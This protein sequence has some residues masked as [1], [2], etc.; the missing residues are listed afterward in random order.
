[1]IVRPH[2][3]IVWFRR[4]LRLADNPA[5]TAALER[6]ET[7][8][9]LYIHSP[10]EDEAGA[11]GAA[12]RFW[13][14]ESL[15]ALD[16]DLRRRGSELVLA[17]GPVRAALTDL[18]RTT[19]A[20]AVYWNRAYEP[21]LTARDTDLKRE[22]RAAGT[23]VHSSNASL[24]FEP[25]DI[26]TGAGSA[27]RVY[28]PYARQ[29]RAR[30]GEITPPLPAP[31]RI[32]GPQ[33]APA[34]LP[35]EA[36]G[37]R[38]AH[39]W[40]EGLARAWAPGESGAQQ[41]LARFM[42]GP[43]AGY[44]EAR[45]RPAVPGTSRL[46][47]HLHFGELSPRQALAALGGGPH[48]DGAGGEAFVRELLWREFAHHVLYHY[49]RTIEQPLDARFGRLPWRSDPAALRAWQRGQT[50]IPIVDA[51]MRELWAT[52][53]MHNRVR[54]IVASLLCKNLGLSWREGAAWFHDT[55]V[56]ADL[57]ANVFGWQW[58]AGCGA[59]AAPYYRIFNPVLQAE[60][61][62][63]TRAYLRRWLP[64]LA[65]LPDEW[66]H[67]PDAA[68]AKQLAA[69]GVTLERSYPAPIVDLRASRERALKAYDEVR[70][71]ER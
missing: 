71:G 68:P 40:T 70:S 50:G 57:A 7:V 33:P 54:M 9:P 27:Y 28:T 3:A 34:G 46:S 25:W 6:A 8:V 22:L 12:S 55:L 29:C 4:D 63:P 2:T 21:A 60:R 49:P 32:P 47:P 36:L 37:L 58:S 59:D 67:R 1:M 19:G 5:L 14:H 64:E 39:A 44:A 23:D 16:Q 65:R 26:A 30:L 35:L 41:A 11:P 24:L 43:V 56:D 10:G 61:F 69:A 18:L 45:D 53:W 20:G 51:G 66:I 38:A 17:R 31:A 42:A 62:D 48:H 52:G 15:R 13:L